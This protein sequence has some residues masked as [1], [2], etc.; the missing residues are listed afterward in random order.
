M[1]YLL[2]HHKSQGKVKDKEH[3]NLRCL[4]Q[5]GP[6]HLMNTSFMT[7]MT[8]MK[9]FLTESPEKLIES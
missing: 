6:V 8:C 5:V 7:Q 2:H 4:V 9:C 1:I 3:L